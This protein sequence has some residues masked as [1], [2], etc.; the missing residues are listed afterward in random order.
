M[1]TDKSGAA[2][3]LA[4]EL[5]PDRQA[6]FDWAQFLEKTS[7]NRMPVG[8]GKTVRQP[9]PIYTLNSKFAPF[10]PATADGAVTDKCLVIND[11]MLG[12]QIAPGA[13]DGSFL[14]RAEGGAF[15]GAALRMLFREHNAFV[16]EKG[17][18]AFH[19]FA[20][21][22]LPLAVKEATK[23]WSLGSRLDEAARRTEDDRQ[24]QE[25]SEAATNAKAALG[26]C[27]E[28][29]CWL[30][31]PNYFTLLRKNADKA[32]AFVIGGDATLGSRLC[33]SSARGNSTTAS[34]RDFDLAMARNDKL[35]KQSYGQYLTMEPKTNWFCKKTRT[36]ANG[37]GYSMLYD[38]ELVVTEEDQ[39]SFPEVVA[40]PAP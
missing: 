13:Q 22:Y 33:N 34:A 25:I 27:K 18:V 10:S 2:F 20:P 24:T 3:E 37:M 12:E 6:D 14:T 11:S 8:D 26:Y 29:G 19:P 36:R 23:G 21:T 4:D 28:G 35:L 31:R 7:G 16:K 5:L 15:R 9:M 1:D 32:F 39:E 38:P 17:G 40:A 30:S